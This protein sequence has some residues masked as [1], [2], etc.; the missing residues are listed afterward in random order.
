MCFCLI[1]RTDGDGDAVYYRLGEDDQL[2]LSNYISAG[3][4]N[5]RAATD[6]EVERWLKRA[7]LIG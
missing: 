6:A 3:T 7:G 1:A 4:P 5:V 2:Q